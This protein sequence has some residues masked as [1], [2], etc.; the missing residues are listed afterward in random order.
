[1]EQRT[2]P[3]EPQDARPGPAC[4]SAPGTGLT[5]ALERAVD[6]PAG[7]QP[8]LRPRIPFGLQFFARLAALVAGWLLVSA[9]VLP[10]PL[11]AEGRS[12]R[13]W[14]QTLALLVAVPAA[15]RVVDPERTRRSAVAL[16]IGGLVL[17]AMPFLA[18]FG[19]HG[20]VS[21]AWWNF[22]LS[23]AAL[24]VVSAVGVLQ[25][26]RTSVPP[27]RPVPRASS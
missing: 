25:V 10:L 3:E 8:T 9:I 15:A 5:S 1:M 11:N 20:P 17:L 13:L 14:L 27:A 6:V 23:G 19:L 21:A 7:A 18:G 2:R 12:A 16:L 24:T 22:E 26:F 4:E